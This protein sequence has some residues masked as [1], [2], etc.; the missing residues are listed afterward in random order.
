MNISRL[1]LTHLTPNQ[2]TDTFEKNKPMLSNIIDEF[3]SRK[4]C[5]YGIQYSFLVDNLIFV[6]VSSNRLINLFDQATCP[7][8]QQIIY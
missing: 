7:T 8:L 2:L 4:V 5:K 3:F 1:S 6:S